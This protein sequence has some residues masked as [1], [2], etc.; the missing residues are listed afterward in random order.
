MARSS[1]AFRHCP[2]S[3][4][5]GIA[6]A[7]WLLSAVA[8][9]AILAVGAC[10]AARLASVPT[11]QTY[12]GTLLSNVAPLRLDLP[13][14][15]PLAQIL[16]TGGD[17]VAAGQTLAV[18]D[19][20]AIAR[21]LEALRRERLLDV[22]LRACLL[23]QPGEPRSITTTHELAGHPGAELDDETRA[24]LARIEQECSAFKEGGKRRADR[25]GAAEKA[26]SRE[27]ALLDTARRLV[28]EETDPKA[29]AGRTIALAAK[30]ADLEK[31][32][33]ALD[34]ARRDADATSQS[35]RGTRIDMLTERIA[36]ATDREGVLDRYHEAPRLSLPQ[37]GRILRV[38]QVQG[39]VGTDE[40]FPLLELQPAGS[41]SW[42]VRLDL[43]SDDGQGFRIDTPVN[44]SIL[45][46]TARAQ[47]MS[48][49]V[50]HLAFLPG[51]DRIEVEIVL[52]EPSLAELESMPIAR[53]LDGP[54]RAVSVSVTRTRTT[55]A[56]EFGVA[57]RDLGGRVLAG[58][59]RVLPPSLGLSG[60]ASRG[61]LSA[62]DA[63]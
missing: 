12:L 32:R 15:L 39:A 57:L 41:G 16:V 23:A 20:D 52:D 36:E 33:S 47:Q 56:K 9:F 19:R 14:G 8:C 46:T 25:I 13:A 30:R 7:F 53:G 3:A 34:L 59:G 44:I 4:R 2:R 51:K 49:R 5:R 37:S 27:I 29:R 17:D 55:S 63:P 1:P 24:G 45:G 38:R 40:A 31:R 10:L 58:W 35:E 48:G 11:R 61:A 18:L 21:E 28:S 62:G 6:P 26:L 54:G 60:P 42:R 43:S 22:T 50:R